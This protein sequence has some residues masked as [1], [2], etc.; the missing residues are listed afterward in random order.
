LI[1][2]SGCGKT[3]LLSCM[4]GMKQLDGGTIKVL[5]EEISYENSSKFPHLIGYMPQETALISELTIKETLSFFG[6]IFQ[7]DQTLLKQRLIMIC[8]LLELRRLN[9]RIQ[10]LSG[11]EKRRV[12]FAAALI[13]DPQI[14]ILDE[15]TVGLDSLLRE[16][17]WNFLIESTRSSNK[18]VIITTHYIAE[19]EKSDCCGLMKHGVLLMEDK[20]QNIFRTFGVQNLEEAF[21]ELC[22]KQNAGINKNSLKDKAQCSHQNVNDKV[23]K[24]DIKIST[25]NA[26]NQ[27]YEKRKKFTKQTINA[28]FNKELVRIFR[29]P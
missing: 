27:V 18:T 19:A 25:E 26:Q 3:T 2:P 8:D 6:N 17:I 12:S 7:M 9:N 14:L 29:Q 11:G 10:N 15:P 28:L 1:G 20:P 4:L 16:K 5:G 13:H 21:L 22:L 23:V 24:E